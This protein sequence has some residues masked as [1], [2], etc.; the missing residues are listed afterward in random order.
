MLACTCAC[1]YTYMDTYID[2]YVYTHAQKAT[3][4]ERAR[5]L[6]GLA[7]KLCLFQE[8]C[9]LLQRFRAEE[10]KGLGFM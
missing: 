5:R 7:R 2:G 9:Q 8:L 1:A 10:D 3:A 6:P 4:Q